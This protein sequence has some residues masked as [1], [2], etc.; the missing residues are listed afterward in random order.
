MRNGTSIYES[1]TNNKDRNYK[2]CFYAFIR[3]HV[4]VDLNIKLYAKRIDLE[5]FT[6]SY[7][8]TWPCKYVISV[9]AIK[10]C[11]QCGLLA[12]QQCTADWLCTQEAIRAGLR[13][14]ITTLSLTFLPT[15]ASGTDPFAHTISDLSCSFPCRL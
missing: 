5:K 9:S 13:L 8:K 15:M 2:I 1:M 10:S 7:N 11:Q 14:I 6:W 12:G 4:N 3:I